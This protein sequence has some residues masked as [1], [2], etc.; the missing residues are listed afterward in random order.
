MS[1]QCRELE[2][3]ATPVTDF[4]LLEAQKENIRPLS[5]GRSAL[6]LSN[7]FTKERAE[8]ER[9]LQLGHE[10]HR[11]AV[12]VANQREADGE[13][14]EEGVMDV[15]D[16]YVKYI[17]FINQH[18]PSSATHLLPVLESTTRKFV[19]DSRFFQDLRYL[20]L[21]V[22]YSKLVEKSEDIWVF[23]NSREIGT[24]HALMYE[25]WA[26]SCETRGRRQKADEVYRIGINRKAQPLRR[27][28]ASYQAFQARESDPAGV[29]V[30]ATPSGAAP[31]SAQRRVLGDRSGRGLGP[32]V[33][34]SSSLPDNGARLDVFSEEASNPAGTL[35]EKDGEWADFGTRDQ[36]RRENVKEASTWKGEVLPQSA[37]A[38]ARIAPRTPKIEVF[39]DHGA[40]GS[41]KIASDFISKGNMSHSDAERLRSDPLKNF[42]QSSH[43]S[44]D[45]STSQTILLAPGAGPWSVPNEGREVPGK[46][47]KI[48]RRMFE[49]DEVFKNGEEWSFEEI[50]A[51]RAGLLGA[52]GKDVRDWEK[53]WHAPG[54]TSPKPIQRK[55]PPSPTVNTKA[56]MADV[57]EL[58][59]QTV[60]AGVASRDSDDDSSSEDDSDSDGEGMTESQVPPTPLPAPV[61]SGMVR[62]GLST[63]G[64]MVPPTPTPA[65]GH[66]SGRKLAIPS[67]PLQV[68]ADENAHRPTPSSASK[69]A[70]FNDENA[71]AA[72]FHDENNQSQKLAVFQDENAIPQSAKKAPLSGIA[73]PAKTPLALKATPLAMK[74]IGSI[75]AT[76]I[77]PYTDPSQFTTPRTE[78][79]PR[80]LN[81]FDEN[82]EPNSADAQQLYPQEPVFNNI[83]EAIQEEEEPE[84]DY[85]EHNSRRVFSCGAAFNAMTP[86]TERTEQYTQSTQGFTLRSSTSSNLGKA[87][88][89]D[90]EEDPLAESEMPAEPR[91]ETVTE[92]SE[93][94]S[95]ASKSRG[96]FSEP[97][98]PQTISGRHSSRATHAY[99]EQTSFQL[100]PGHT[101][102][103]ATDSTTAGGEL[104]M[105]F[106][107]ASGTLASPKILAS[108][109]PGADGHSTF[110]PPNP[111][112]PT[113][114]DIV[115]R[116]VSALDTPLTATSG[117][118]H[119]RGQRSAQLSELQKVFKSSLRRSTSN[120]KRATTTETSYRLR[121]GEKHFEV[122]DK[123]GE[124]GFGAVFRAI[125]LEAR[126]IA[127]DASDEEDDEMAAEAAYTVAIKVEQPAN[128]WEAVVL[129]RLWQRLPQENHASIVKFRGLNMFQDESMLVLDFYSQGTLLNAVNNASSWGIGTSSGPGMDEVLAV[130]FAIELM[131]V[132]EALHRA[133]FIHGDLKID[134]CLVRLSESNSGW[135]SQYEM[136]GENGWSQKGIRL[137]DFGRAID[138]QMWPAGNQQTFIADWKT[139]EKDCREIRDGKPWSYQADYHGLASICYCMLFGKYMTIEPVPSLRQDD[140][141]ERYKA[142]GVFKRY[143][144]T[145]LWN[146]LFDLLLNPCLVRP[147]GVL[148]ISD[149]LASVRAEFELWLE[150]NCNKGGKNLKNLLTKIELATMRK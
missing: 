120:S 55:G 125:D 11:R 137:I 111:C 121:I 139:D 37:K 60:N 8:A 117:F 40:V 64:P 4:T 124:G 62:M 141:Q 3:P 53:Q 43:V 147:G 52:A 130:F 113:D 31:Q 104:D 38:K 103:K 33:T 22:Q 47:G 142:Q 77:R 132:V 46:N 49:W 107:P 45:P 66:L 34:S 97:A 73:A 78:G 84:E 36:N 63:P 138:F 2:I 17:A 18:H 81:I 65:Q 145:D 148:P 58:F 19:D 13:E 76:P 1:G 90:D 105:A 21:W 74:T 23:L 79:A 24:N 30:T 122:E 35:D 85:D 93:R 83:P 26:Q 59:N 44:G 51:R 67:G 39:K 143:W 127:D 116:L 50:R 115:N 95:R 91:L 108:A 110:E 126:Q 134:N 106:P 140:G 80:R 72:V 89:S 136:T 133:D 131:K 109:T 96:I 27:L 61:M 75:A 149:E 135:K 10:T 101:I 5:T 32:Q 112:C 100:S 87:P 15:L 41:S 28:Q 42:G 70:L 54:A 69:I 25:E 123:I 150:E 57:Y 7:I 118:N 20:K 88:E 119:L 9:V 128:L 14:M 82:T 92:N 99:G 102:A 68:F 12:D 144:Q 94:S 98:S 56:A 146:S 86:I 114:V 16:P 6:T 29:V 48:E 129:H 71:A